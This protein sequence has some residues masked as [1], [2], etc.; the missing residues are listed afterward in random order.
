[1]EVGRVSEIVDDFFT[2]CFQI[3]LDVEGRQISLANKS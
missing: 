2:S 3:D 1:M